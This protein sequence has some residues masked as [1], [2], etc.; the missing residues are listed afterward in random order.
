MERMA[1]HLNIERIS[2]LLDEPWA[3][4]EAEAHLEACESCRAEFERLSRMRMAFSAF[5]DLEPPA[6]GWARIEASL[7]AAL[8]PAGAPGNIVGIAAPRGVARRLMSHGAFQAAAAITLFAGGI[9]AGLQLTG[10]GALTGS[11][12]LS[13]DVPS[14]IPATGDDRIVYNTL[15]ELQSLR[16]PLREVGL[17]GDEGASVSPAD[18]DPIEAARLS[19]RLDGL[20]RALRERLDQA[21][22]DPLASG[23]LIQALDDRAR[24]AELI[25]TTVHEE[26]VVEW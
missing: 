3:D 5:G 2:A 11:P 20:I 14:V 25:E 8:G 23:Y 1:E 6:D 16:T 15:S 21:P 9:L 10:S 26:R 7:D 13:G 18:L 12:S 4:L 19:A 17:A 22:G 24:L